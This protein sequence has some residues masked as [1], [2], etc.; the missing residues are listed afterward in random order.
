VTVTAVNPIVGYMMFVG[1]LDRLLLCD[2]DVGNKSALIDSISGPDDSAESDE[3]ER[4]TYFG[5]TICA[6]MKK[7]RHL[8][9]AVSTQKIFIQTALFRKIV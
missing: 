7:L 4:D 1:E 9:S 2:A 8:A 5:D 3:D 6:V